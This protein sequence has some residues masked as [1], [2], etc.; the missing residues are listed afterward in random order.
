MVA[1]AARR[2]GARQ[3]FGRVWRSRTK[4]R[5]RRRGCAHPPRARNRYFLRRSVIANLMEPRSVMAGEIDAF[6]RLRDRVARCT[7]SGDAMA[8]FVFVGDVQFVLG[9][10]Q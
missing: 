9:A 8:T 10:E 3:G 1:A 5:L 7:Q 2:S 6:A 4:R